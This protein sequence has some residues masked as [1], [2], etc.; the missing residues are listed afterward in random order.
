ML[1]VIQGVYTTFNRPK[2]V[3]GSFH[4]GNQNLVIAMPEYNVYIYIHATPYLQYVGL[5][6]N[7]VRTTSHLTTSD[8]I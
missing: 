8:Y 7:V 3:E 4:Q 2:V 5:L 1:K 6:L